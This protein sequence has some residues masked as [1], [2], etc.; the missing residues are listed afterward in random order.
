MLLG[1][2]KIIFWHDSNHSMVGVSPWAQPL[3]VYDILIII[4]NFPYYMVKGD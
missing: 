2:H 1:I 4:Y 3:C